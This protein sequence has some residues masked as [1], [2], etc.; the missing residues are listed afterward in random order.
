MQVPIFLLHPIVVEGNF[1][2][3]A[4][5][6]ETL[7]THVILSAM[8]EILKCAVAFLKGASVYNREITCVLCI[9]KI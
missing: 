1:H 9:N 2:A 7:K 5:W 3:H 6:S 4:M 8:L